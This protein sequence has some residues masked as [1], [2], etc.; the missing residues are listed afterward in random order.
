MT[1]VLLKYRDEIDAIDKELIALFEKRMNIVS[2]IATYKKENKLPIFNKKREEEVI[3]KN[4]S[5][6]TDE[7]LSKHTEE[8]LHCLMDVSKKYQQ[9]KI[10]LVENPLSKAKSLNLGF[11]GVHGSFS[12]EALINYFGDIY[13][14]VNYEDFE[15]L[16]QGLKYKS[17]DYGIVPIE[18]SSTG[19]INQIYDLLKKYG[20]YIVGETRIKVEQNLLAIKGTTL[21]DIK[22]I[23]SHPQGFEQ[24]SEFIKTLKDVT[25]I[26]YHN[27]GISAK[28]VHDCEDISKSAIGSKRAGKLYNL[29]IL[30][31]NINNNIE[32]YTRFIIIGRDFETNELCNKITIL[33]ALPNE[34]GSLYKKLKVFFDE[35]INMNKIESRPIGDGSFNYFFYID[36]DGNIDDD[37]LKKA[38]SKIEQSTQEFRLLGA[39]KRN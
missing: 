10:G 38:I 3:K 2:E 34:L 11:Q 14:T 30:K 39:Y 21:K 16:F 1:D 6:I 7:T 28:Y 9:E 31:E 22:C 35:K 13:E 26:P 33:L 36:I 8:M 5:R 18:N 4:I 19:S 23:Y 20:F 24:S 29:E 25:L 12:E 37:N 15:D 32:N 27:T 17:I